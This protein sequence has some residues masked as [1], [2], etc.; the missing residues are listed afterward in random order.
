[1]ATEHGE[2]LTHGFRKLAVYSSDV[3]DGLQAAIDWSENVLVPC[4]KFH[5]IQRLLMDKKLPHDELQAHILDNT[6][7]KALALGLSL[8][9]ADDDEQQEEQGEDGRLG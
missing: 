7:F 5:R 4:F 9:K 6:D 3:E 8:V 1:M 2:S